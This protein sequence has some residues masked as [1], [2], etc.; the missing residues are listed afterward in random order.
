MNP[1]APG[2]SPSVVPRMVSAACALALS[3]LAAPAGVRIPRGPAWLAAGLVLWGAR[4][5]PVRPELAMLAAG[6]A[7]MLLAAGFA[8]H[9]RIA[10]AL[11]AGLLAAA[12][13]SVAMALLQYFGGAAPFVPF[14][15]AGQLGEAYANLRQP[16]QFASF[17][18]LGAAVLL[19]APLRL[20]RPAAVLLIVLLAIGSAASASRTAMLQG[21]LLVA[22]A[23]LWKGPERRWRLTLAAAA[24]VAY[25]AAVWVLPLLLEALQGTQPDRTLLK[26]M[27]AD[28]GCVSRTVLWS[29]VLH[30]I[31]QKPLAGWGWGELDFAHF[32]SLY[33]GAR[34][35]EILDNAH[36]LPLHLAV[37]LGVPAALA[38]CVI[39]L[40]WMWR[41]QPWREDQPVRQLAWAWIVLMLVH[42]ML[43]YPLWYGPFQIAFGAAL[44]WLLDDGMQSERRLDVPGV[45]LGVL[46]VPVLAYAAWDYTRVSQSIS[47][48]K[49]AGRPGPTMRRPTRAARG[50]F[51]GR[52]VS[53]TSRSR[54][55]RARTRARWTCSP[56][57]C[58][59]TRPSRA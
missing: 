13:V 3:L 55:S 29:N 43:E 8:Q 9:A 49:T 17:C 36:N 56:N 1:F 52:P 44:G 11:Q 10:S 53:P 42:A 5:H 15:S 2:P 30:L 6:L 28:T 48:P 31:A 34:F 51:R 46:L 33:P 58:C 40:L 32:L 20:P 38:V 7:V 23:A 4:W 18:W 57:A 45:A 19:W 39:G 25:P 16:N 24:G 22:L 41:A 59:T 35:C 54:T 26:R 27:L 14:V 37:E 21:V 12:C 50:C 47:R